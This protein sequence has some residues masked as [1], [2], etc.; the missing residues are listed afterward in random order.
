MGPRREH[1]RW[2]RN[3]GYV[4][5]TKG[6][7]DHCVPPDLRKAA[8][9]RGSAGRHARGNVPR[10]LATQ[11]SLEDPQVVEAARLARDLEA[12]MGWP[13]DVECAFQGGLLYLL[14]C[15]PITNLHGSSHRT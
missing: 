5:G 10:L 6:R 3:A 7:P 11:S 14:Q 1:C 15:R 13:A 8:H 2:D 4:H 12:T 9:D